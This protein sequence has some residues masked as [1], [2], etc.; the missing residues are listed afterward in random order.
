LEISIFF[1][2]RL[3]FSLPLNKTKRK[4]EQKLFS[5]FRRFPRVARILFL[6]SDRLSS[7]EPKEAAVESAAEKVNKAG[8]KR[9]KREGKA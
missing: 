6:T 1:A 8:L 4:K 3:T 5:F 7:M 2:S 9:A